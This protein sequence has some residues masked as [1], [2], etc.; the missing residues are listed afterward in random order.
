MTPSHAP[1]PLETIRREFPGLHIEAE[2]GQTIWDG[3][4][5][6]SPNVEAVI[7]V[8]DEDGIRLALAA[9][10][11]HGFPLHPFCSGR[12]WGYG[13]AAGGKPRVM[14]DLGGMQRILDFDETCGLVTIEAGVSQGQLEAFLRH[15]GDRWVVSATGS[16]PHCSVVSNTLERGFGA[17]PYTDHFSSVR[18]L[19]VFLPDGSRYAGVTA[20]TGAWQSEKVHRWGVGPHLHGLFSQSHLGIVSS[21]TIALCRRQAPLLCVFQIDEAAIVGAVDAARE[22]RQNCGESLANIKFISSGYAAAVHGKAVNPRLWTGMISVHAPPTLRAPLRR[23]VSRGLARA[24]LRSFVFTPGRV[25]AL[26]KATSMLPQGWTGWLRSS[27]GG[28]DTVL[29]LASGRPNEE[30]LALVYG[31]HRP[32]HDADPARDRRGVLWYCP[33]LR[34]DGTQAKALGDR[35]ASAF[36]RHGFAPAMNFTALDGH[37]LCGVMALLFDPERDRERAERCYM[38]L[39]D[40]GLAL[41]CLPYR[42]PAF[43][44]ALPVAPQEGMPLTEVLRKAIDPLGVLA[45]HRFDETLAG[46][47]RETS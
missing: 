12:N 4:T 5:G 41:G 39:L 44:P 10:R 8:E 22:L 15:N 2:R 47:E 40:E 28:I 27:L 37:A 32:A 35:C 7:R 6:R 17:A 25:E 43:C 13:A 14:L 16:S 33:T 3:A 46:H 23:E 36:R 34:F 38:D 18:A 29:R 24:G 30:A 31:G 42:I 9:A 1:L 19:N 26:H 20:E 21:M 11:K 45:P